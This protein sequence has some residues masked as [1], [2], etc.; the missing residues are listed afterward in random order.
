M[1]TLQTI[2]NRGGLLVSIVIGLAL[3]AFIVGDALNSGSRIFNSQRNQIGEIAGEGVSIIDFQNRVSK[4]EE[5]I[6]AMNNV[7]SL[8]EEQQ[9]MLRENTW[10][11][12]IMEQLMQREYDEIGIDV[13]GDELYDALLGENM[14]PA[15]RQLFTNPNTGEIDYAGARD[16][17][18]KVISA[19][20][21]IPQ[22]AYWLNMEKEV[23]DSRKMAKY[24][25]IVAKA[26]YITDAQAQEAAANSADKADIS[27]I[28]KNYSTIEDSTINVSNGEIKEYY[29]K[30][31]KSFEQPESRKIVYVNFDIEP[32]GED[33]SETEGA[34][35]DLVKEFEESADPLEFVNLSSDKKADRNYFKQ[36]EIAND[37]MAQFLF[38]NEKAV[39]G[40]YLENN[41]YKI[42]RVASVKMLPDS[43][44]AR[45]ILIAPQNQDYA[46]AKNIADSLADLLRKGADF[47]ELAKTNSIDQNSAVNGGDLGWFTS[48]TMVQPFSDSAF[49]AKKN[50]IK[51]VLTQYGAHVLQVTDMAKPVKKIQIAT[52]EKE[53]SPSAKTTNQI[54]ND[55]RTFAIEV[56]NLDNFNK[57]VEESGLT[58]RIA[59]IGKNDKTIAGMES[60]R[61]MIRQA[62]MAEEVDEVLKTNDGST[63]FENGN[64]FTIAVLTEIDEEGIAPL[65]KVAGNIKR[66]LI[67][68]KKADLLKKELASA[69]SGSESL[70]SIAQKAGLEV[71]EANEISFNSFQIPG[72]GIEPKVIAA[73]SITE[74]GKISEPIEGNQGVSGGAGFIGSHLCKRL[75]DE[76]NEV[77]CLDNYFTGNKENILPLIQH[78]YFE[79]IRHDIMN[80]FY[81]EVDE[82]YNLAC[83]ASP[84]HYQY[85]PIRTINTSVMGAIN[86]LGLANRVK[87]KVMQASTSEVYGDPQ[88][89]PQAEYYWGN[90]NPIG[91]RSC[92]DEGKR[93]AETIFMDYHRQYKV[94][95]K[96]I[97]IFN[98]YGPNMHPQDGRV[99]SNFIVQALQDKDLTIYG[100]GRQTRSFQYV[101]DLIRGMIKMM[102]TG[103]DFTG[104]VNLGNPC[105]FTILQLAE[106]VLRLTNSKSKIVFSASPLR[107][108]DPT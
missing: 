17:V 24:N 51:V 95:I 28:V 90:V 36:D 39:F 107:R 6:K 15:L 33:F 65:N 108:S 92:Y 75:L 54:Y 20:N 97:R 72:A 85:D 88:I 7:S 3:I 98:T 93:C 68:K 23:S 29:N 101:D 38:N 11:Q 105:E 2:R 10:Q 27:Y 1:A 102:D 69:K 78:P 60:A 18:K 35:N 52:V 25:A 61:E 56:S 81:A 64:K 96:I 74:Q 32:S 43:V 91:I 5:M 104:P 77:L 100:N 89:H 9:T 16:Y 66:I 59:T 79:V 49:F 37:S 14:S 106:T 57:K 62:Y 87:C 21:N 99:V 48:R 53:V 47:E 103:D 19:P 42:S 94:K 71:K 31:Q 82:I 73:S 45:H 50:D 40:P 63:I 67:Q 4:N 8:N 22:K 34:V 13:S 80:S 84:I 46:Q 86:V 44:R 83:P 70:L 30:H 26:L 58:K 76:G 41:A 12:M 55:A